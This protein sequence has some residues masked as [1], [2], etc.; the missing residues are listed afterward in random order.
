MGFYWNVNIFFFNYYVF[1]MPKKKAF[2]YL[3][4]ITFFSLIFLI[5]FLHDFIRSINFFLNHM[6]NV[7]ILF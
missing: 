6:Q 1:N 7:E 4:K 3:M 2:E 5:D